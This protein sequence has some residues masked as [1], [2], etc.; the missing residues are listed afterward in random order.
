MRIRRAEAADCETLSRIA[1]AAKAHWGYP[2]RWLELWAEALTLTP[3]YVAEN[4]VHAAFDGGEMLGFYAVS[5]DGERATLEHLWIAPEHMGRSVGRRLFEHAVRTAASLGAVSMSIDSDPHAEGFYLKAGARRVGE[6]VTSVD[7]E[8]RVL[9]RLSYDIGEP[10]GP[11][12][13][14]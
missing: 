12:L 5:P 2:E 14:F 9:P 11:P 7:G 4:E 8:R 13:Y 10:P 6:T 1:H 3:R